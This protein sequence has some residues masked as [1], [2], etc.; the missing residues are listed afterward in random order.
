MPPRNGTVAVA[1]APKAPVL[2]SRAASSF[3]YARAQERLALLSHA[4]SFGREA[5]LEMK[6]WVPHI[7][8]EFGGYS[9]GDAKAYYPAGEFPAA[10]PAAPAPKPV[11]APAPE[12]AE[13]AALS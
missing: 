9:T 10:V 2:E 11:P 8:A 7:L 1:K 6:T 13:A 4:I 12:N 3:D 5:G